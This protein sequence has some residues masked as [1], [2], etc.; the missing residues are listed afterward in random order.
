[1]VTENW[2]NP[3]GDL[4]DAYDLR[5]AVFCEEQGYT[6]EQECDEQDA[7]SFHIVLYDDGVPFATGR[8]YEESGGRFYIGRICVD[9]AR[10]G[11]GWGHEL[12][13]SMMTKAKSLGATSIH[14]GAQAYATGFYEKLGFSV[15]GQP[16][17]D[18]HVVH[19]HMSQTI[20][21]AT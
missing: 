18:G 8:I 4:T 2:I 10:R 5:Y 15:D 6:K 13:T 7:L 3:H 16:Y 12:V 11:S 19:V 21:G 20:A 17:M 1:M 9:K 14:L